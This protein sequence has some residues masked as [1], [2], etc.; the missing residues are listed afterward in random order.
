MHG[1][2]RKF[3][4]IAVTLIGYGCISLFGTAAAATEQS[5]NFH[6]TV[7][8]KEIAIEDIPADRVISLRV[9]QE[10]CPAFKS[11]ML[12]ITKDARLSYYPEYDC[13]HLAASMTNAGAPN[14]GYYVPDAN[15]RMCDICAA[16]GS[17]APVQF[18]QELLSITVQL[19]EQ[20]SAGDFFGV[21][22]LKE[23]ADAHGTIRL[24]DE[25]TRYSADAFT[26]L[27]GGG[28]RIKSNEPTPPQQPV[29]TTPPVETPV[30]TFTTATPPATTAPPETTTTVT[31]LTT[32]A[33]TTTTVTTASL[34]TT[35]CT[36]ASTTVSSTD[37][38]AVQEST[39]NGPN[40]KTI[41]IISLMVLLGGSIVYY[42]GFR[43]KQK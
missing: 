38:P 41:G 23:H 29:R 4:G 7:E 25:T 31:S 17:N 40:W 6:L 3:V 14:I 30:V 27:V 33:T 18:E 20:V 22:I 1:M 11:L 15:Y 36:E 8:T 42:I 35:I 9:Y 2:I 5:N 28:I 12:P 39:K 37:A 24:C 10:N 21:S 26:K 19:P 34:V 16:F 13:F 43:R 32:I